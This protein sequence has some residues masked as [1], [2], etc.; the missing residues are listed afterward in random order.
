M[1]EILQYGFMQRA[2]VAGIMVAVT[3]PLIGIFIV[4]E[5]FSMIG[6]TLSHASLAGI[7]AGMLFGFYPFW[8][9]L[10]F[11]V[12]AALAIEKLRKSFVGYGE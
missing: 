8:G 7:S 11:S 4:L 2:F 1:I 10:L 9:A 5:R 12:I 6:D 3:C